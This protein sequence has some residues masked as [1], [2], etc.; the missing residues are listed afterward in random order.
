MCDQS[1][2]LRDILLNVYADEVGENVFRSNKFTSVVF[3]STRTYMDVA[4]P[5]Q[6]IRF[7]AIGI[8]YHYFFSKWSLD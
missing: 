5:P 7:Y 3:C 2:N 4:L 8:S 6:F 1:F